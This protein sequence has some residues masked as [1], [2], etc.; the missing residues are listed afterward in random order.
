MNTFGKMPLIT[1]FGLV[2]L[3]AWMVSGWLLP[4]EEKMQP[5]ATV[6]NTKVSAVALPDLAELLAVPLFGKPAPRAKPATKP[7]AHA[8]PVVASRLNIKLLGTVV[9]GKNSAAIISLTGNGEQQVVFVGDAIQPGVKLF[10]VEEA[11]IVVERAGMLERVSLEQS[12]KLISTPMAA[13][14]GG[15]GIT[16][17]GATATAGVVTRQQDIDRATL[18]QKISDFPSLMS[19]ARVVPH[20]SD[21][22]SDGF[23]ITDI[24][25]GS[26]YQQVG[27]Q[28]GDIIRKVNGKQVSSAQQAM[29]MYKALESA[30]AID[31][32]LM[33]AGQVQQVHYDIR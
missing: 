3:L 33:R 2:I 22:K 27:L 7:V 11:A 28:N 25:I 6:Q 13:I 15:A 8:K 4:G 31:L 17:T 18:Q 9:A 30:T 21:G 32:E 19:E 20:F 10:A 29:A 1:E 14:S 5:A 12:G 16:A 24:V 23:V 26:L